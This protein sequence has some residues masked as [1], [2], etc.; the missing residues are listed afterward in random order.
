MSA[1]QKVVEHGNKGKCRSNTKFELAVA[2]MNRYFNLIGDKMPHKKQI[3]ILAFS[4]HFCH[5]G[6]LQLKE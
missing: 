4:Q 3:H 1:G 2:W 6:C 5:W